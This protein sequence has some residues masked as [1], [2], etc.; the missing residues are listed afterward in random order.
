MMHWN[1]QVYFIFDEND[2]MT[3]ALQAVTDV[4]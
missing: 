4:A 1:L 3:R 2:V